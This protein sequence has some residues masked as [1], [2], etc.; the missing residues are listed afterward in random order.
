MVW[1]IQSTRLEQGY[2]P[3]EMSMSMTHSC[4]I[5]GPLPMQRDTPPNLK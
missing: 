3:H 4:Q 1:A 2:N 5:V